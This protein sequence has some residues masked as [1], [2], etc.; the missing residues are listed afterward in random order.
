M[1]NIQY[2]QCAKLIKEALDSRYQQA[3]HLSGCKD[4]SNRASIN[5]LLKKFSCD[6]LIENQN[7][8]IDN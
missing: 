7:M 3:A 8:L 6:M 2:L 1:F 4:Q 5:A